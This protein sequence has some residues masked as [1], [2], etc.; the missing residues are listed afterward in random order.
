ML[1]VA[2]VKERNLKCYRFI[3]EASSAEH[4]HIEADDTENAFWFV[5]FCFL[6]SCTFLTK[7]SVMFK[8]VPTNS[9]GVAHILEHTSMIVFF[10]FAQIFRQITNL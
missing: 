1:Q 5:F 7:R 4:L 2:E 10:F 3:H 8:T 9:N 6:S